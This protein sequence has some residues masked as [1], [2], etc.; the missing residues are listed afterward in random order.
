MR[1]VL[2]SRSDPPD[3]RKKLTDPQQKFAD[4]SASL[5]SIVGEADRAVSEI[6]SRIPTRL[7]DGDINGLK[8]RMSRITELEKLPDKI[9][10]QAK[11]LAG[12]ASVCKA[13]QNQLNSGLSGLSRRLPTRLLVLLGSLRHRR[14]PLREADGADACRRQAARRRA[15]VNDSLERLVLQSS[16][17]NAIPRGAFA[18]RPR[19]RSG[20][21][22]VPG[23]G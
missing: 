8:A 23:G 14:E 18:P 5:S 12:S 9:K 3:P 17:M 16:G 21:R 2:I 7:V 22:A 19:A 13:L 6:I 20:L 11:T 1:D 10:E 15:M 4:L